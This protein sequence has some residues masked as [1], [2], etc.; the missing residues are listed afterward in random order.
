[1][2][3]CRKDSPVGRH[4]QLYSHV[5]V[6]CG[7]ASKAAI[8]YGFEMDY[9]RVAHPLPEREKEYERGQNSKSAH[10]S[11]YLENALIVFLQCLPSSLSFLSTA[12]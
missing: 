12:R 1:M 10:L 6:D 2:C 11:P 8:V 7:E 5:A 3:I 4:F 9:A